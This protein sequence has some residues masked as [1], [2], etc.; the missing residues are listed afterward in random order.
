MLP[1]GQLIAPDVPILHLP[2]GIGPDEPPMALAVHVPQRY[3]ERRSIPGLGFGKAPVN[4]VGGLLDGLIPAMLDEGQRNRGGLQL[5]KMFGTER[6]TEPPFGARTG[7][8]LG[9]VSWREN[10]WYGGG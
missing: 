5:V 4:Q 9:R 6:H 2:G 1:L 8:R 10:G 3:A 7:A